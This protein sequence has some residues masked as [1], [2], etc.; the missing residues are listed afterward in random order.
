MIFPPL[1]KL[2]GICSLGSIASSSHHQTAMIWDHARNP[3]T[4]GQSHGRF[5]GSLSKTASKFP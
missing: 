3:V 2:T 1:P 5:A 4:L